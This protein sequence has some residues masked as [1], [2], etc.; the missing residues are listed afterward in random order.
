MFEDKKN[1]R[2]RNV[3]FFSVYTYKEFLIFGDFDC[4]FR[5]LAFTA[6]TACAIIHF[7]NHCLA[8]FWFIVNIKCTY[9]VA[10]SATSTGIHINFYCK[11]GH[12]LYISNLYQVKF[13]GN[14][15][16]VFQ[17]IILKLREKYT[18]RIIFGSENIT[19]IS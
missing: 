1:K 2:T 9:F 11:I 18:Q 10:C 13:H 17:K 3:R 15:F 6:Q 12:V 16:K 19:L 5:T 7:N 14:I 4:F 8:I